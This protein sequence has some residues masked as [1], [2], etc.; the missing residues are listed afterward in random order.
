VEEYLERGR[1]IEATNPQTALHYYTAAIK[2]DPTDITPYM[3]R[4][5]LLL[6]LGHYTQAILDFEKVSVDTLVS[7]NDSLDY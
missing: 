4:G 6:K 1:A 3:A 7:L 2:L 5:D